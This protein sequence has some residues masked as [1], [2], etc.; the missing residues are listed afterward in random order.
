M[1]E[2]NTC[3]KCVRNLPTNYKYKNCESC[4][5]KKIETAKQLGVGTLKVLGT[6]GTIAVTVFF[7]GKN[8]R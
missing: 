4:R 3:K 5:N 8:K 7:G 6:V 2:S 1:M